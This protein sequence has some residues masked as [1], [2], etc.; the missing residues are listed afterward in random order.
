MVIKTRGQRETSQFREMDVGCEG[1][2]KRGEHKVALCFHWVGI[3]LLRY[4]G[5]HD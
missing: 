4:I 2:V 1:R 3:A 5:V